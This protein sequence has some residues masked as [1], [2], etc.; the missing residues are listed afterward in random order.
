VHLISEDL[1]C[2]LAT[3]YEEM[4]ASSDSGAALHT[5]AEDERRIEG[6]MTHLCVLA[7]EKRVT[8]IQRFREEREDEIEKAKQEQQMQEELAVKLA[9]EV[10]TG[11]CVRPCTVFN[12]NLADDARVEIGMS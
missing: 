3:A 11:F 1:E 9:N 5:M 12:D 6:I 4:I 8:K 2:S 10:H 7:A